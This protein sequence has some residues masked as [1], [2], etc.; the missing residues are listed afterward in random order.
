MRRLK[1]LFANGDGCYGKLPSK[2]GGI[3][4]VKKKIVES[5]SV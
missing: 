5:S 3:S 2:D 4:V 1:S